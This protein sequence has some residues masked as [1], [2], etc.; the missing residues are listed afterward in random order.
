MQKKIIVF[1]RYYEKERTGA[2]WLDNIIIIYK[3][4]AELDMMK[5]NKLVA[6]IIIKRNGMNSNTDV[7]ITN[8]INQKLS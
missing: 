8:I 3:K 7:I 2:G 5:I 1:Y 4:G 6:K